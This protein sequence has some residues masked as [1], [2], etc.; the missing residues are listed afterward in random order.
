MVFNYKFI[1]RILCFLCDI[2]KDAIPELIIKYGRS[3]QGSKLHI[4]EYKSGKY[5]KVKGSTD[6]WH[7]GIYNYT[8]GNGLVLKDG[9]TTDRVYERVRLVTLKKGKMTTKLIRKRVFDDLNQ[10][11]TLP[12]AIKTYY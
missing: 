1:W 4:Y 8:S 3:E 12:C 11:V 9:S 2:N 5:K 10:R 6:A 7:V